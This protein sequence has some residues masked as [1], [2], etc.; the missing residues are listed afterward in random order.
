M[1]LSM[2]ALIE[3]SLRIDGGRPQF[4]LIWLPYVEYT[5][6]FWFLGAYVSLALRPLVDRYHS[7]A[8]SI[9]ANQFPTNEWPTQYHTNKST[10]QTERRRREEERETILCPHYNPSGH[11]R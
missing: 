9:R 7:N 2:L 8:Y 5:L 1:F 11:I 3:F 4:E 10:L 6:F